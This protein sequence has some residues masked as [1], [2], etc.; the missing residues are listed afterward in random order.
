MRKCLVGVV[1]AF[2]LQMTFAQ[3]FKKSYKISA[4][5][6]IVIWNYQGDIKIEGYDGDIIEV[7]AKKGGPDRDL[8][9]IPDGCT[10]I[11]HKSYISDYPG[12]QAIIRDNTGSEYPATC[13][14]M[15]ILVNNYYLTFF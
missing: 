11:L 2:S 10:D 14:I 7:V 4:G 9:E 15:I 1:I 3:D 6:Q 12:N 5:G 13:R 8:I